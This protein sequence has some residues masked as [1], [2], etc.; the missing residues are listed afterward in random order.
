MAVVVSWIRPFERT[1]LLNWDLQAQAC[2]G[3][4]WF[5]RIIRWWVV[6]VKSTC[7]WQLNSSILGQQTCPYLWCW[8]YC[9]TQLGFP[10]NIDINGWHPWLQWFGI[11]LIVASL[12]GAICDTNF[13]K[14]E[15]RGKRSSSHTRTCIL[16]IH[17]SLYIDRSFASSL[18]EWGGVRINRIVSLSWFQKPHPVNGMLE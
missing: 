9:R 15:Q 5:Q 8:V 1:W 11:G 6:T 14:V 18:N 17:C 12:V 2:Y 13:P 3:R 10:C 7:Y 4:S 16:W